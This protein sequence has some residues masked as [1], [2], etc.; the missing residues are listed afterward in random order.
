V[1]PNQSYRMTMLDKKGDGVLPRSDG[2]TSK[3]RVCY[4]AMSGAACLADNGGSVVCEGTAA[5]SRSKSISCFVEDRTPSPSVAPP[6][7][8]PKLPTFAPFFVPLFFETRQPLV[9]E[10]CLIKFVIGA[11][12]ERVSHSVSCC[13][14]KATRVSIAYGSLDHGTSRNNDSIC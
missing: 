1:V 6:V 10:L 12:D 2:Q 11:E 5:F 7:S 14:T 9:S 13:S 3:F 4:G 8:T